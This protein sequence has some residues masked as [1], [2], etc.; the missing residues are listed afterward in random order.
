MYYTISKWS[1]TCYSKMIVIWHLGVTFIV[2]VF[3]WHI[4]V[5]RITI[6]ISPL[7]AIVHSVDYITVF[8]NLWDTEKHRQVMKNR[9]Q[10]STTCLN[11]SRM[12]LFYKRPGRNLN[13][14][15]LSI[16]RWHMFYY[17]PPP[18]KVWVGKIKHMSSISLTNN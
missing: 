7:T 4:Y 18:T 12:R 8:F 6:I 16:Y 2:K 1:Y 15:Y 13:S 3:K 11:M 5:H 10:T 14:I 9:M 17:V